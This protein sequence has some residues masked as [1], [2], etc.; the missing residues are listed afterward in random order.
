MSSLRL[1][2]SL[3]NSYMELQKQ[4]SADLVAAMKAKDTTTLNVLRVLK[5]EIQRAEQIQKKRKIEARKK[6]KNARQSRK[7]KT[8]H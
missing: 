1:G 5:G 6:E 4:I 3:K 7:K 2:G 8:R